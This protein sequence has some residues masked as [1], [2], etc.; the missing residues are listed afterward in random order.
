M[1]IVISFSLSFVI[2]GLVSA[3]PR[4][5]AGAS[6]FITDFI[7]DSTDLKYDWQYSDTNHPLYNFKSS[8]SK[9]LS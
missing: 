1:N 2:D 6:L 9:I 3:G 5:Q 4:Q 7:T 8:I